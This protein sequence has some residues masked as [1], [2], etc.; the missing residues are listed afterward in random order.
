MPNVDL[1]FSWYIA[2]KTLHILAGVTWVFV[3][4]YAMDV[5][6]RFS[7]IAYVRKLFNI[8][9]VALIASILS[10]IILL[11]NFASFAEGWVHAKILCVLVLLVAHIVFQNIM[12]IAE[13]DQNADVFLHPILKSLP[14]V[15]CVAIVGLV[16]IQPF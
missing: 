6:Q 13:L 3:L 14:F 16:V 11:L 5:F 15:L 12:R 8:S 4:F 9:T 10:G 7:D 2:L 1:T